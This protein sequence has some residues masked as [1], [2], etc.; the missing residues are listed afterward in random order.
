MIV[1]FIYLF[2]YFLIRPVEW[3]N[4]SSEILN[5]D[6]NIVEETICEE[7]VV[8]EIVL[9][10]ENDTYLTGLE[11]N[12]MENSIVY[13]F[14][15]PTADYSLDQPEFVIEESLT[16][17]L[18]PLEANLESEVIHQVEV[19]DT[20]DSNSSQETTSQTEE[21]ESVNE[22]QET[23]SVEI[24]VNHFVNSTSD[25][26]SVKSTSL[27]RDDNVHSE[28][29]NDSEV[30]VIESLPNP[31]PDPESSSQSFE[32]K[33]D[34]DLKLSE[35]QSPKSSR[36]SS[37]D[38][39]SPL[40]VNS[41]KM[42]DKQLSPLKEFHK[43]SPCSEKNLSSS[44]TDLENSPATSGSSVK[45]S[46]LGKEQIKK[47]LQSFSLMKQGIQP[48]PIK[49]IINKSPKIQVQLQSDTYDELGNKIDEK[50]V[51]I[52]KPPKQG[53]IYTII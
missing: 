14:E 24:S 18:E 30:S 38:F 33:D 53:S 13:L 21:N 7:T 50:L 51:I 29:K 6:E 46:V 34:F 1:R 43:A 36:F 26:D 35:F 37:K 4:S 20:M 22:V 28:L 15:D 52:K 16:Y 31:E 40:S 2:M 42:Q 12:C 9:E 17:D 5:D 25:S 44:Q 45:S 23:T 48:V 8:E 49:K 3:T 32:M 10:Q 27:I 41:L 11:G 39:G 47:R 19:E